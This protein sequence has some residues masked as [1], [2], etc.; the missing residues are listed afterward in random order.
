MWSY[1]YNEGTKV[2]QNVANMIV[3][4]NT[5]EVEAVQYRNVTLYFDVELYCLLQGFYY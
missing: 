4:K 2:Q 1:T 5:K 3:K